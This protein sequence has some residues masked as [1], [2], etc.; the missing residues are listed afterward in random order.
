MKAR[1]DH[2]GFIVFG[3]L[4]KAE[5]KVAY[6]L[7]HTLDLDLFVV[8]KRMVLFDFLS[9]WARRTRMQVGT[10]LACDTR[11][12]DHRPGI[13]GEATHGS[14]EVT[15]DLHDLFDRAALEEL[16]LDA[17]LYAEDDAFFRCDADG[18]RAELDGL[19][20]ILDLEQASLWREGV[21]SPVCMC[22]CQHIRVMRCEQACLTYRIQIV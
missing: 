9:V 5:R 12:L 21:H 10:D 11:M 20:R 8:C 4:T 15:V 13:G 6:G 7:G 2:H 19:E 22:S 14:A 1:T 18:S 16:G 3:A 17:L